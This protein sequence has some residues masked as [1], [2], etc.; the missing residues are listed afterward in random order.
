MAIDQHRLIVR[1]KAPHAAT[2]ILR[3]TVF[4]RITLFSSKEQ[5]PTEFEQ[6][7]DLS[8]IACRRIQSPP[9]DTQDFVQGLMPLLAALICAK[10]PKHAQA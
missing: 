5:R 9:T 3:Q 2:A 6:A 8:A 7:P 10:I 4:P 1:E